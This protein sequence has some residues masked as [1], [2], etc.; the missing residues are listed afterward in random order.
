MLHGINTS[1][2]PFLYRT[3]LFLEVDLHRDHTAALSASL[4]LRHKPRARLAYRSPLKS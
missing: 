3:L 4:T 2:L 1:T